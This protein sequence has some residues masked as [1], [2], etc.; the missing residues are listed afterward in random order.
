MGSNRDLFGRMISGRRQAG[1]I[2][3]RVAEGSPVELD[4]FNRAL[5]QIELRN[6][7][8]ERADLAGLDDAALIRLLVDVHEMHAARPRPARWAARTGTAL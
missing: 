4:P 8:L 5:L 6:L 1:V 7:G 3:R 2:E